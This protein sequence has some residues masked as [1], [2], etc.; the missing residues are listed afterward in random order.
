MEYIVKNVLMI[1]FVLLFTSCNVNSKPSIEQLFKDGQQ[2]RIENKIKKAISNFKIIIEKYPGEDLSA[3][4]QFQIADIFLN[5]TKDFE[6]AVKEFK[7][8]VEKYPNHEV[9]KKSLFLIA[10][11]YNNYINAYSDAM[12]YYNMF[13][14]KYPNVNLIMPEMPLNETHSKNLKWEKKV[15]DIISKNETILEIEI[16]NKN[17]EIPAPAS[18]ILLEIIPRLNDIILAGDV[19]GRIGDELIPSVEYELNN[20]KDVQSKIDSLNFLVKQK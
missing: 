17:I 16:D 8:V 3:E 4:A 7:I 15:G 14:D 19:I 12:T 1:L 13:K 5:D 10:Y 6:Y 11:I 2:Y 9:A 20:L 18:G